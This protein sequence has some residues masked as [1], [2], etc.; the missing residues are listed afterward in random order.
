M[1]MFTLGKGSSVSLNNTL[2]PTHTC[3]TPALPVTIQSAPTPA[4]SFCG[5]PEGYSS[6]LDSQTR[7]RAQDGRGCGGSFHNGRCCQILV[8]LPSHA[9]SHHNTPLLSTSFSIQPPALPSVT[10]SSS[11]STSSS[12]PRS[13]S[14][15]LCH[16]CCLLALPTAFRRLSSSLS[17]PPAAKKEKQATEENKTSGVPRK[18]I[19]VI[20]F[21]R[22]EVIAAI[23]TGKKKKKKEQTSFP[24]LPA[25]RR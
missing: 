9:H 14:L 1:P 7:W 4:S 23:Y 8:P 18:A 2:P 3:A 5:Y 21:E 6:T 24:Y 20:L 19:W 25:S 11:S 17:F 13:L 16:S 22:L 12:T 15:S 10:H